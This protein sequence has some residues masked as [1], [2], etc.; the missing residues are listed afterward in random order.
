M[1]WIQVHQQVKDHRKVQ[2]AADMLEIE[3]PHMLGLLISFWLWS[4]DNAPSGTLEGISERMIARA[5]QWYGDPHKFVEAMLSAGLLDEDEPGKLAIH[6]WYEYTGKLIDQREAE[7][8][9][10]RRRRAAATAGQPEDDRRTTAGQT[11]GQPEDDREKAGGRVDQ[12]RPEQTRPD[13][14]RLDQSRA[15]QSRRDQDRPEAAAADPVPYKEIVALYH[16]ICKSW[17]KLR[18]IEGKRKQLIAA[19]YRE[20][21]SLEVFRELFEAAMR[22]DFLNGLNDRGWSADFNW[23]LNPTNMPKVLEGNYDG[24]TRAPQAARPHGKPAGKADTLG[25]LAGIIAGEEGGAIP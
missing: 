8:N 16:S 21:K 13:Q 24:T 6:D 3:P 2:A 15:K 19:R 5:A 11:D 12:T 25:V 23:L 17:P 1:A 4:L 14:S 10:S 18:S 20:Y 22:S 7:K 9:R